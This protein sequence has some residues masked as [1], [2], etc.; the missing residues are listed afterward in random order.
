MNARKTALSGL[1]IIIVAVWLAAANGMLGPYGM[2]KDILHLIILAAVLFFTLLAWLRFSRRR[3]VAK[4]ATSAILLFA[5]LLLVF[6]AVYQPQSTLNCA[7]L[8]LQS[9]CNINPPSTPSPLF[10]L[11]FLLLGGAI[12]LYVRGKK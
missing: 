3:G 1:L 2:P 9:N 6:G 12:F 5:L 8:Q 4:T 11:G 10:L 7:Q